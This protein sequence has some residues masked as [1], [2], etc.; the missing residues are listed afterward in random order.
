MKLRNPDRL[1]WFFL[2]LWVLLSMSCLCVGLGHAQIGGEVYSERSS[3][4]PHGKYIVVYNATGT[5][6]E[7]G[8]LL[9]ADTTGATSQPQVVVGKGVKPWTHVTTFGHAQRVIGV[10]LGNMPGYKQGRA[11]VLGFHPWVKVDAT[12]I[13]AFSLMK[14]STL[15]TTN[16][17]MGAFAASDTTTSAAAM[18]R[19]PIIGIFQRYANPDSLRGYV[20]VNTVGA[21]N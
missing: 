16:G 8:T 17:A 6:I 11:L 1:V 21:L 7:D 5:E 20:W 13:A 10:L 19:K 12:G 2:V 9:M 3:S 14:P 4:R 15:S 18:L